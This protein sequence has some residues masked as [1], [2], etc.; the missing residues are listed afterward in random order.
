MIQSLKETFLQE[1]AEQ[2][3]T[4]EDALLALERDGGGQEASADGSTIH[5]AFRAA[6][7]IKG[8]AGMA[9]APDIS[10]FM[11]A[12]ENVLD[13]M[14][15]GALGAEPAL[16]T[17][18][19]GCADHLRE[20]LAAFEADADAARETVAR[21]EALGRQL[22]PWLECAAAG[23]AVAAVASVSDGRTA[24]TPGRAWRVALQPGPEI[25]QRGVD[26]LRLIAQLGQR[27]QRLDV[28][29][30]AEALPA[31]EPFDPE[32]SYLGFALDI[33]GDLAAGDIE[34]AF[35]FMRGECDL[36]V[37]ARS[38]DVKP[39]NG[40]TSI[41]PTNTKPAAPTSKGSIRVDADKLD[42]L[43][44]LVGELVIA[45]AGAG[46][47]AQ[48]RGDTELNEALGIVARR[49]EELREAAMQMR[50]VPIAATFNRFQRVVRDVSQE[51]GKDIEL[52]LSGGETELDKSVV[53]QVGDP[54]MHLVRNSIDHGIEPTALRLE[55]GKPARGRLALSARHEA[56]G[57]V[58]EI[59][60]DGGGLDTRRIL[61]KAA[62]RGLVAPNATP[63]DAEIHRLI[64]E[65]G[66]STA[67]RVTELSGRGVGMDVVRR[68]IQALRGS[69]HI[70]SEPGAGCR[71]TVRLPLTLAIIDGF[72]VGVGDAHFVV[73]LESVGE[74]IGFEERAG[75]CDYMTLHGEMLP[76]VRLRELFGLP[77][78]GNARPS[79]NVVVVHHGG[80]KVG[81]VVER[82]YGGMQ[83]VIKPLGRLFEGIDGLAGSIL[84]GG[85]EIALFLDIASLLA[86]VDQKERARAAVH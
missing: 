67:E 69:I 50:M 37:R 78:N 52:V 84:L 66:F 72:R 62:E 16:I 10:H 71:I 55:R 25:F 19:L 29:T 38:A 49:I 26:P 5:T 32:L 12:V 51:L 68:N 59:A 7:T 30:A 42:Q 77:R 81:L 61:A 20:L 64:F 79:E 60:D 80:R 22:Q 43:M 53:E 47:L 58:I 70:H 6:H 86:N 65:P 15:D 1:A 23:A 11:H 13:R 45:G 83:A 3:Q 21:G 14:R 57:I 73:P 63:S 36:D 56:G 54:L 82:L 75:G 4:L 2:L 31:W 76:Y 18:M 46:A 44:D 74:C 8:S 28:T 34:E 24:G 33:E 39:T 48:R 17:V 85:G 9:G 35:A 27:V 40:A 41:H